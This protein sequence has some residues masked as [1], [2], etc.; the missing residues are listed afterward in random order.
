MLETFNNHNINMTHIES[1]LKTFAR[2][3]P[4]FHIDFEG[5]VDDAEVQALLADLRGVSA[6]L[7]VMAP[8]SVPWFPLNIRSVCLARPF[9][10]YPPSRR[11]SV[12]LMYRI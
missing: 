7:E 8:R 9:D 6:D 3:G 11:V 1:R 10:V 12:S 5:S 4:A 2:Q